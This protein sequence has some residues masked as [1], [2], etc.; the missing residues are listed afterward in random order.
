MTE[1]TP[2]IVR[3]DQI[4]RKAQSAV[5]TNQLAGAI[6]RRITPPGTPAAK[7]RLGYV[8]AFDPLTW[9]CTA[10]IGDLLTSI[11]NIAVLGHLYPPIESAAMFL[12]TGGDS[13]TEYILIGTMSKDSGTPT[14]GQ[15]FRIRKTADQGV[16]NSSASQFDAD[17]KFTAQAGRCYLVEVLAIVS[18]TGTEIA[19]DFKLGL[20]MPA[21]ASWSGGGLGPISSLAGGTAQ[22]STGA[23]ANW[24]AFSNTTGFLVYGADINNQAISVQFHGSVKM[25]ATPG[26]VQVFWGQNVAGG[27]GITTTVKEGS[28]LKADMTTEYVL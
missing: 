19:S 14:Y 28:Y 9:T 5:L 8:Q 10:L 18:K 2:K 15:T 13:T 26:L 12:Q 21:G 24:R 11:P 23:G 17:L 27:G 25:G 4:L 7:V 22:E 3:P 16:L 1:P 20:S 6:Q